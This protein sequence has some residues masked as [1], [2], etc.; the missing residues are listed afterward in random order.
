MAIWTHWRLRPKF[1]LVAALALGMS[2]LPATMAVGERWQALET[3]QQEVTGVAPAGALLKLL[4]VTQQH[5]GLSAAALA[6]NEAAAAKRQAVQQEVDQALAAAQAAVQA[7]QDPTLNQRSATLLE[8]W[9]ALAQAVAGKTIEAPASF[10]R[11]GTLVSAQLDLLRDVA[12]ATGMSLDA[13]AATHHAIGA[14]LNAPDGSPGP[15]A[16]PRRDGAAEAGGHA[17][18]QGALRGAGHDGAAL[19][20][21]RTPRLRAARAG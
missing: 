20:P 7:L 9:Q 14:T 18:G 3:A 19:R 6:G 15:V 11:H 8:Q 4:R 17:G 5:R 10:S 13:Q 21:Q 1:T 16:R 12:Q 2:L